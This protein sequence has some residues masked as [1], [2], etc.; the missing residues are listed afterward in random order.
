MQKVCR[1]RHTEFVEAI[2][3]MPREKMEEFLR[4]V[5]NPDGC[6]ALALPEAE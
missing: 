2:A 4:Y 5:F 6:D 1:A 3:K